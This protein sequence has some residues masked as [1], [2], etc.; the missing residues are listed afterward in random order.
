[1]LIIGPVEVRPIYQ[2]GKRYVSSPPELNKDSTGT[3]HVTMPT[4]SASG[5]EKAAEKEE[6]AKKL[7]VSYEILGRKAEILQDLHKMKWQF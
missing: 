3:I 1:M 6:Q 2:Q 5:E 7:A 4:V